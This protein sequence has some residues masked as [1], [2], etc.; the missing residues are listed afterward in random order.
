[1]FCDKLEL[2]GHASAGTFHDRVA[3]ETDDTGN[4]LLSDTMLELT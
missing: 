4:S 3:R 2:Y 1:M